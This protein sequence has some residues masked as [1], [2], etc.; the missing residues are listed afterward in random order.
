MALSPCMGLW[1]YLGALVL[2]SS[3][4]GSGLGVRNVEI[5]QMMK[6]QF[7]VPFVNAALGTMLASRK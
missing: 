7:S 4:G 3:F 5:K 6:H 1:C 2:S